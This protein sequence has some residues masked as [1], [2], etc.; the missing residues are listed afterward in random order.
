VRILSGVQPSGELHLGNYFGAVAQHLQLQHEGEALYF[1]ADYHAMTTVQDAARLAELTRDV[2]ATYVAL[3]LDPTKATFFR[4]SDVPEVHELTWMLQC[5]TG[6]G[7]LE[8]ATSF[9]DKK[10]KGIRATVGL[11]TYPALM[12][13]DIL[14]YRSNLVPVGADQV[15][16]L[17]I[18]QDMAQSFNAAFKTEVLVR[19]KARLSATPKVPGTDGEKMSKSYGNTIPIFAS[20]K[21]LKKAI[22]AIVTD[23]K[24]PKTEA[25]DPTTC[26]AFAIYALFADEAEQKQL[27]TQYTDDRGFLGYGVT[28]KLIREKMDERFGAARERYEALKKPGSELDDVLAEGGKRARALARETLDLC[29]D[30]VGLGPML[31]N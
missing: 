13:S 8:R 29:R 11:F 19:P 15:Q 12:A 25:L 7:L 6:M 18:C 16:H 17:E 20:G 23:S 4:Q 27:A 22:N 10:A 31:T 28:K 2:A 3:G 21:R 30:A 24:D 26:N 1:I 14:I 5:V 9:K